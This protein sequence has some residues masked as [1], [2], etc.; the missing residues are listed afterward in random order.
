MEKKCNV[1]KK[2]IQFQLFSQRQR[3]NFINSI[4]GIKPCSLIGTI[5]STKKTNLSIVNSTF[6]LG[7][8]PSLVGLIIRPDISPR[9]TL[10][11]IRDIKKFTINHVNSDIYQ[12]AHQTSARY[13]ADT[14]EFEA[15]GLTEMYHEDFI[16]PFVSESNIQ[17]AM[18]FVREIS[19]TENATHL[20][21]AE[22][23]SVYM[24]EDYLGEDKY[25]NLEKADTICTSGLETYHSIS[26]LQ[27]LPYAKVPSS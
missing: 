2:S 18:N 26:L 8:N 6:H 20:I 12:K 15:T 14:S 25:A 1:A 11:N 3:I 16:A 5:N 27:R 21:I 23:E 7:A 19:I 10:E 13:S 24:K 17:L 9:H 22:I 4:L